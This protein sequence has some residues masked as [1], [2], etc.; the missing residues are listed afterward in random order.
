MSSCFLSRQH[1]Y[2]L[3]MSCLKLNLSP[4]SLTMPVILT[5][6]PE[7]DTPLQGESAVY[8]DLQYISNNTTQLN[9]HVSNT[10][11]TMKIYMFETGIV[12]A[13]EC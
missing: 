6:I 11:G 1:A 5:G 12:R 7:F 13:N 4:F 8:R 3:T 9:F 2:M 10:F